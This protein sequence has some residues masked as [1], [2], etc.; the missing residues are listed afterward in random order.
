MGLAAA[1]ELQGAAWAVGLGPETAVCNTAAAEQEVGPYYVANEL[2]RSNIRENKPGLPLTLRLAVL[3]ARSCKP[4][5][6]AAIDVWHC[7]A[8]GL[9][10]GYTKI[11]PTGMGPGGPPPGGFD[12]QHRNG[13]PGPPPGSDPQHPG[14]RPGPPEGMG[15]PPAMKQTDQL[16]FLRGIQF[17]DA[18]G[19][20]EF[21][22]VFPGFYMGRTNH[23][24]FKVRQGGRV[25][26]RPNHAPGETYIE[27]HTCHTGQVFF[28]EQI[29]AELMQHEPYAKHQIHR[30]TQGEDMVF[31]G[32]HGGPSISKLRAMDA[33]RPEAG[34][35]AEL[36][37]AVDPAAT[38]AP[39]GPGG[40]GPRFGPPE[41]QEKGR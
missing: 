40:P 10:A 2:L 39:V 31:N 25:Q 16:T 8:L 24:H 7:D 13:M 38:P 33:K 4:L 15:A 9:Y 18:Q 11:D 35:V 26:Q 22:T 41:G 3:D 12:P 6:H 32:Q 36:I 34:Y 19:R 1:W 20:V 14:N 29:A 17:T 37:V 27:G 30:T 28:P 23:I 5:P 21:A